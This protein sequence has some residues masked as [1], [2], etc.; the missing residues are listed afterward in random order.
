MRKSY[1]IGGW[2]FSHS[3]P[4]NL[5]YPAALALIGM[6]IGIKFNHLIPQKWF[7]RASYTILFVLGARLL[8]EGLKRSSTS[9][10]QLPFSRSRSLI[11]CISRFS[12]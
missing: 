2:D 3:E 8:Y 7:M 6:F 12:S 11:S 5:S 9:D 1:P 4:V 10:D